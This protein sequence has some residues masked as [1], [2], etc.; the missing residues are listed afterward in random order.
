MKK[1]NLILLLILF[2]MITFMFVLSTFTRE[3]TIYNS[4]D[5]EFHL[6]AEEIKEQQE[7]ERVHM[8]YLDFLLRSN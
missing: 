7:K 4:S 3:V 8:E 6:T 5:Y 1:I 2:I